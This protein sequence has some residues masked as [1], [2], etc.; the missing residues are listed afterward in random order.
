MARFDQFNIV[1]TVSGTMRRIAKVKFHNDGSIFVFFPGFK[2]TEGILCVAKLVAGLTNPSRID[3]T[4]GGKV[5]SHLVKYAHH[6]D[7]EAHF[8]Q[9]GKVK[10]DI[11]RK[12]V[13]LAEQSGHLFTIQMQEFTSFPALQK[14]KEKQLTFNIPDD[15]FALR[16][17]VWRFRLSDMSI[18]G[19]IP[20]GAI[21][22]IRTSNGVDHAGLMVLP[23]EGSPFDDVALFL[24]V[25]PMPPIS[26]DLAVHLI[27]L[28]GFDSISVA[29]NHAKDTEF[30]AF[31]YP[32]ADFAALKHNI[33]SIDFIPPGQRKVETDALTP[34]PLRDQLLTPR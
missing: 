14:P 27:F 3:L 26:E 6:A 1:F 9:D 5:A 10:T 15:V 34:I 16:L 32:C 30:L 24:T 22:A 28:G 33:G 19:D 17:I 11:R 25:Q 4:K 13:P 2:Y 23:P 18:K 7:G 8:S 31:A 12:A 21:P 20:A 29:L